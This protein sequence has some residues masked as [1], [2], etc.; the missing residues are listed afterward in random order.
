MASGVFSC[1]GPGCFNTVGY[2]MDILSH[3]DICSKY[4]LFLLSPE[5][6]PAG[7]P[8]VAHVKDDNDDDAEGDD[9]EGDDVEGDD[10]EDD[11]IGIETSAMYG[12]SKIRFIKKVREEAIVKY[13]GRS[14]CDCGGWIPKCSACGE[15]DK[16]MY[17]DDHVVLCCEDACKKQFGYLNVSAN[18]EEKPCY[19]DACACD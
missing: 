5:A 1:R 3:E 10:E 18:S 13:G 4:Q 7:A 2:L 15:W 11:T 9:A 19:S 12:Y 14:D 8:A 6:A 17:C 16:Y